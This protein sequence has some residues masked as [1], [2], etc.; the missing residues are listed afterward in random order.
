MAAF[1]SG[2]GWLSMALPLLQSDQ[3]PL[4]SGP[5]TVDDVSWIG[6]IISCGALI[7]NIATGYLVTV[8]GSKNSILLLGIPQLVSVNNAINHSGS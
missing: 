4:D 8:I 2:I 1:G 5:L 6:A 3:T 7:A